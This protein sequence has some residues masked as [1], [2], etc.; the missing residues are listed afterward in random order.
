[1]GRFNTSLEEDHL[2][3]ISDLHLGNPS[4]ILGKN[5]NLFLRHL[6]E[7]DISLCINGDGLD[8]LQISFPRLMLDFPS[9]IKNIQ[10]FLNSGNK[11]IYYIVG[12]HDIYLEAFLEDSGIFNVVP[13]LDLT[14][15]GKRIHIEHG[16]LYDNLFLHHPNFYTQ[17]TKF[18]GLCLKIAP[19][20]FRVWD[21]AFR[22]ITSLRHK[23]TL[24]DVTS[25]PFDR[26]NLIAAAEELLER[27]FD[28]V[29]FGHTH[30]FGIY[31][32]GAKKYAN[33]GS[34]IG[35]AGHYIEI[36]K[37]EISLKEWS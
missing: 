5:F 33:T 35:K 10:D 30:H 25:I 11:R 20:L 34:W 26:P 21:K 19:G 31:E 6:S 9:V 12:N 14:S 2:C 22:F 7:E 18:M 29:I 15:G 16:H 28:V 23:K 37:G 32:K 1:M 13:F 8:L 4:F 3:I 24:A 17:L 27:G 36:E